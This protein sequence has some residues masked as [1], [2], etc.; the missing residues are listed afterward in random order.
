MAEVG[1]LAGV[2]QVTVS[3]ALSSPGKVSRETLE[4]IQDAI[5]RTGYVP[6]AVAGALASNKS[7]LIAALVPSVTNIVYSSVLHAFSEIMWDRGYQIMLSET[8]FELEREEKAIATHLSRRPDAILL[9]GVRHSPAA[10]RMLHNAGIPVVE[11]WDVSDTPVDCCVG[12]SHLEAGRAAADFAF[13]AGYA[14][15]ATITAGDERAVRRRNAFAGRFEQLTGTRVLPVDFSAPATLG[16]GR[17]ALGQ[18]LERQLPPGSVIFCSSDQFA[19]GALVE[20]S[21]RGLSIPGDVAVI[22]FGDQEFAAST[23]PALTSVRIDRQVLGQTAANALL[24]RFA[25]SPEP[26]M[27][28]DI[29]FEIIRRQSA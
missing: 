2:S 22:G 19:Q 11:I 10:R 6:N 21:A 4:R 25:A 5:A 26:A 27:V 3:R 29:G 28:H 7:N 20:A 15:A 14:H 12:F 16:L 13:G 24:S 9:T 17:E 18:L 1:R 23:A 8:G